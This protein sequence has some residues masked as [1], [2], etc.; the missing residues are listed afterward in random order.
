MIIK[1]FLVIKSVPKFYGTQLAKFKYD[2]YVP[3][4]E[5]L[6][7]LGIIQYPRAGLVN[8]PMMG[9]T[10]QRKISE[11]IRKRMEE[12]NFEEVSLS[13]ISHR[14]LWEKTGRWNNSELFKLQGDEFLLAPT[15][16]EE[17]CDLV[18]KNVNSY[19]QFPVLMYQINPKFRNEKR[20][21]GGLLRGKEFIMKDAYSFDYSEEQAMRTY[22]NVVGAYIKIFQDLRVDYVKAAADS[23]DIGGSLSHEWHCFHETG[24]D[25]VFSCDSCNHTS[26]S[27]KTLSFP[28]KVVSVNDVSVRYFMTADKDTL[29]CAYY[30]T[31]RALE[32]KFVKQEIPEIDL[33]YT[34]QEEILAEFSNQ[35]TLISKSIVRVMDSRLDSRSNFPDFPIPFVSRSLITM[36]TDIPIVLA[37]DGELCSRCGDGTLHATKA[38]ELGHTFYLGDKYSK[39][40]EFNVN[41]PIGDQGKSDKKDVMMGCYGIGVSRIIATIGEIYR[42]SVGLKWPSSIAPWQVTVVEAPGRD[43]ESNPE[44]NEF[45]QMLNDSGIDYRRDGR[46]AVFMAK[47]LRES[48]MVGIPM[49]III[50][51]QFPIVEIEIRGNKFGDSWKEF[52]KNVK[53]EFSWRVEYDSNNND[54]KHYVHSK[55]LTAVVNSL[56]KDL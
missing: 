7:R 9:L 42:D 36:L 40:L 3:T 47:K 12:I 34:N 37:E 17:I 56:L 1:R 48:N 51:K 30:P 21:R 16:E 29:V 8:W 35:D 14:T 20:P 19:K 11:I 54:V 43:L 50:G 22:N 38:I 10:I 44:L 4:H 24:E 41:V 46:G 25:T 49:A 55:G 27:E 15:A 33:T 52:Y 13:S 53:D 6:S 39:P 26:N 28:Q 5:V 32:P 18:Y 31:S 23:G 2:E 45:Y